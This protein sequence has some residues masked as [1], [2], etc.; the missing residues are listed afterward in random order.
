MEPPWVGPPGQL[1]WGHWHFAMGAGLGVET[2]V[3]KKYQEEAV[4]SS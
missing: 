1:S 2:S 4:S 3:P